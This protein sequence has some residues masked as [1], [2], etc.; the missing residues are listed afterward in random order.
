MNEVSNQA[1]EWRA[2]TATLSGY[3]L[4]Q[5]PFR[6][7]S[8]STADI[9]GLA[10]AI[11]RVHPPVQSDSSM[12]AMARSAEF[13]ALEA[14]AVAADLLDALRLHDAYM[15]IPQDR[16]GQNGPKGKAHQAWLD[17]KSAAIAKATGEAGQ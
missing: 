17:A 12:Q 7:T 15:A 10:Q 2:V 11:L 13:R 4:V 8:L 1:P 5:R 16:G 3:R 14:E 9:I 6:D